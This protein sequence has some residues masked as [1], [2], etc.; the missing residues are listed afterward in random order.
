MAKYAMPLAS[1]L[2]NLTMVTARALAQPPTTGS[3]GRF[4]HN[5]RLPHPFK[6]FAGAT[7]KTT[8]EVCRTSPNILDCDTLAGA[9]RV[10]EVS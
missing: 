4:V 3:S 6:Q 8:S 10:R 1:R 5:D 7:T 2:I 9:C